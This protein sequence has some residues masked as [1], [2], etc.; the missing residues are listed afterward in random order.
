[1]NNITVIV[2]RLDHFLE[3]K[4]VASN[5]LVAECVTMGI[6]FIKYKQIHPDSYT[7]YGIILQ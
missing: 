3:I 4:K 7:N 1:M 5:I 6:F 2:N